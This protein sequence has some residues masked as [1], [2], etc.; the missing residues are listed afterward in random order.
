MISRFELFVSSVSS[1]YRYIQKIERVEMEK[2]G[3]K[4]PM[5]SACWR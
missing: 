3:L 2:Y 4:G 1:I 5:P